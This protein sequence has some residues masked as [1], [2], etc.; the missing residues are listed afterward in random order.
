MGV[1]ALKTYFDNFYSL[2]LSLWLSIII[3]LENTEMMNNMLVEYPFDMTILKFTRNMFF[4][5]AR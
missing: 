1:S 4:F 3:S 2:S 5:N